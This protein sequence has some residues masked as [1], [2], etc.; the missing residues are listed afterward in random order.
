M[1]SKEVKPAIFIFANANE[2]DFYEIHFLA[3]TAGFKISYGLTQRIKKIDKTYYFGK[4]KIAELVML[5]D[6]ID[7]KDAP[8]IVNISL[9]ATQ[10]RNIEEITNRKVIDRTELIFIIFKEGAKTSEAKL[11]VEIAELRYMASRMV[12]EEANYSQ[13]TSGSGHNKGAGEKQKELT[14]REITNSIRQKE[15]QLESIKKARKTGRKRRIS[16]QIP[17]ISIVG[18]TNAGKSTL[19]NALIDFSK[20]KPGKEVFVKN[21]MFATLETSSRLIDVYGY[22]SFIVSDTVGFVSNLPHFLVAAF[23]STL[24]EIKESDYIIEVVDYSSKYY[25]EDMEIAESILKELDADSIPRIVIYNKS[26]V[27]NNHQIDTKPNEIITSLTNKDN[28]PEVFSFI[29][30]NITSTWIKKKITFPLDF[31]FREFS[32]DNYVVSKR[33]K[34]DGIEC[35]V[36]FNPIVI[37]KY[38]SYFSN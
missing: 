38:E 36:Y 21:Q 31:D 7:D 29:L 14:R 17:V 37:Y 33:V 28:I 12:D 8:I 13:V 26:D 30:D 2:R 16:S 9:N 22:P 18:Y 1:S 11:Q 24:E 6:S 10:K 5:S 34:K 23:R 19:V 25:Q 15:K 32:K 20:K 27:H 35:L 4:G 3:L